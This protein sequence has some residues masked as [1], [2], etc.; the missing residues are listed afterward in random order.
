M[1]TIEAKVNNMNAKE[2]YNLSS[3]YGRLQDEISESGSEEIDTIQHRYDPPKSDKF[4][5]KS[6]AEEMKEPPPD[7]VQDVQDGMFN[8][9]FS[10]DWD[11]V[12]DNQE[13]VDIVIRNQPSTQE[14]S[15]F[16]KNA[17]RVIVHQIQGVE[18]NTKPTCGSC[19]ILQ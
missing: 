12:L 3:A 4:T 18:V 16:Y 11:M 14:N 1:E 13:T 5:G 17:K 7:I 2:Y 9:G 8:D 19:C 15:G 10:E 6:L